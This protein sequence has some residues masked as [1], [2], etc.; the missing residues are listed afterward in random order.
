LVRRLL[1]WNPERHANVTQRSI[2]IL[3]GRLITDEAF[4]AAFYENAAATLEAFIES[5]HELTAI[6]LAALSSTP[7]EFW[8]VAAGQI[9]PRLQKASLTSGKQ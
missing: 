2:E 5:G 7:F 3:I 4:R 1:Y 8:A 9:D 6:E